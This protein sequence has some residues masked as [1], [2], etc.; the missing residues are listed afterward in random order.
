MI[1]L[2]SILENVA[3]KAKYSGSMVAFYIPPQI[4]RKLQ[5]IYKNTKGDMV[6]PQDMHITIGLVHGFEGKEAKVRKVL[7]KVAE[8]FKPTRCIIDSFD[9]F[10]PNEHNE[11]KWVLYAKPKFPDSDIYDF[12]DFCHKEMKRHKIDIDNGSFE[13]SPHITVKYCE[14]KPDTSI[15]VNEVFDINTLHFVIRNKRW[16]CKLG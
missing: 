10:P 5:K 1:S 16:G 15:S 11:N 4:G 14:E 8:T 7:D 13:F 9:T 2:M 6:M 3:K 12:R